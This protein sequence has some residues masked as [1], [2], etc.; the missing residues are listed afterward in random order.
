MINISRALL[1]M[2]GDALYGFLKIKRMITPN[3][4][5]ATGLLA[6]GGISAASCYL[7]FEKVKNLS[8]R[9]F[10]DCAGTVCLVNYAIGNWL[11]YYSRSLYSIKRC[12]FIGILGRICF[13]SCLWFWRAFLWICYPEYWELVN[14]YHIHRDFGSFRNCCPCACQRKSN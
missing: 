11:F 1:S 12:P 9:T 6:F 2:T 8:W 5:I 3:P 7:P 10:L 14:L 13:G 4:I